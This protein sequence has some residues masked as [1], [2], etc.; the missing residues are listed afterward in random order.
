VLAEPGDAEPGD[1]EP[2]DAERVAATPGTVAGGGSRFECSA[3]LP[4]AASARPNSVDL[5]AAEDRAV[6]ACA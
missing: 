3:D 1:A 6:M 5:R 2:G 4:H